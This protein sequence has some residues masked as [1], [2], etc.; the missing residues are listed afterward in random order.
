MDNTTTAM[1][2]TTTCIASPRPLVAPSYVSA[3]A[4][5]S[6]TLLRQ[7][8]AMSFA[9]LVAFGGGVRIDGDDHPGTPTC[10]PPA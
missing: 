2:V 8:T 7:G 3:Q 6:A 4:V 9:G 1:P 10:D 5:K